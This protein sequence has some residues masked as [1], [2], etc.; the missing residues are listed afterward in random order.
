MH[1]SNLKSTILA[2]FQSTNALVPSIVGAP[3]GGKSSLAR[4][5]VRTL[6]IAPERTTE[7]NPSLRDPV[8]IMGLP[9]IGGECAKWLPQQ[10]FWRLRDDGTDEPCALIVEEMTDAPMAM[11]NPLCRV[12]LDRYAGELK[13]H[14]NLFIIATGNRTEHKSGANRLST[15]LG[16]RLWNLEFE[17]HLDDWVEWALDAGIDLVLVQFLRWRPDL[18][19]AFDAN[20]TINPTPRSWEMVSKVPTVMPAGDYFQAVKGC[21]GDGAA[22]EY[23]GF[24]QIYQNLPDVDNLLLNPTTAGVPTDPATMYALTGALA[25]RAEKDNFD[26][27]TAYLGRCKPEFQVMAV[28]D[29]KKMKPQLVNTRAYVEWCSKMA[30][31][32]L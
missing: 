21:V 4:D 12:L 5:I 31:Q 15:K 17:E 14:P 20:Q 19:Q 8:D 6:G 9:Q 1:Y 22:A 24:R 2:T 7:F 30:K 18:L 23:T 26:R 10:E 11:Q 29:A 25:Q 13:L 27:V 3:G 32:V 28:N 16:N